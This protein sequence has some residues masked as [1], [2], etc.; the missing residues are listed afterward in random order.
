[1]SAEVKEEV[2]AGTEARRF[3]ARRGAVVVKETRDIGIVPGLY[4]DDLLVSTM[5]IAVVKGAHRDMSYSVKIERRDE[6]KN[7][8]SSALLDYDEVSELLDAFHFISE[9]TLEMEG[10]QRDYTEVTYSTKDA[11]RF[12]FFHNRGDQQIF[13]VLESHGDTT[14]LADYDFPKL[15]TLLEQ[16][17]LH[18]ESK[19]ASLV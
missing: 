12:G 4:V 18:L 13:V 2:V 17:K 14:F 11:A 6:E 19:G 8:T 15:R 3:L 5:V 16:A 1:M 10:S 9:K 7:T